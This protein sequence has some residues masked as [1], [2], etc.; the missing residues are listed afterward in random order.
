MRPWT[1]L[2]AFFLLVTASACSQTAPPASA[3]A[4]STTKEAKI[5]ELIHLMGT[6]K[7]AADLV[8][9]Q[10]ASIK[11]L[12][13]FPPRAQDDFV[14][15]LLASMNMKELV[16]LIVPIY[17]RHFSDEDID[18]MLA[19]YRSPVGQRVSKALP[20][21]TAESQEVGK[22]WGQQLGRRVGEKIG[23]K[24]ANGDYGPW[25]PQQEEEHGKH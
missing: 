6:T 4:P 17:E 9:S 18:G 8:K 23:R 14:K 19:F 2:A 1:A 20:Q 25:P 16:D 11:T 10:A 13:P 12:L 24:L 7:I 21:I 5:R 3:T 22:E 15:E